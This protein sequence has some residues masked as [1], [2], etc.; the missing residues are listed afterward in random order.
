MPLFDPMPLQVVLIVTLVLMLVC[1]IA[2][3]LYA[4]QGRTLYADWLARRAQLSLLDS[5]LL[6]DQGGAALMS[7]VMSGA[8]AVLMGLIS[9]A[10]ALLLWL[11]P[12]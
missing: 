6:A 12:Q 4:R 3:V 1:V 10:V 7:S 2:S 9:A 5:E 8:C 11:G